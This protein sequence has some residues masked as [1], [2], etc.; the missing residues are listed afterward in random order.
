[1]KKL[2]LFL[3]FLLFCVTGVYADTLSITRKT[4]LT[5]ISSSGFNTNFDQIEAVVNGHIDADNLE[6][7]AVTA[8]KL[9]P[10]VARSGY[11]L[12]QHTDG[13]LFVDVSDTNPGLELSDG[14]IRVKA[15]DS[16]IERA[17]G[18]I[19]LKDGGI[20]AAKVGAGALSSAWPV[21]AVFI[22]TVSTNPS[23]LLGFG[24]W[25]AFGAGRML[26]GINASD[27]DF[28]TVLETG[29]AK[30]HTLTS[31]EMPSHTHTVSGSSPNSGG[32]ST[33]Q[34][35]PAGSDVSVTTGSTGGG[36]AHSIL[37]PYVI[38]YMWLRTA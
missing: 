20:T 16:T 15:D 13:S 30:T 17:S 8:V 29:G 21:G 10:D 35:A 19:Q 28:D 36:A 38:V 14:G 24:T 37:N 26:V 6:D 3:T 18:G 2:I 33:L 25:E 34:G 9:N 1:M 11:G 22:S 5:A 7:D 4:T 23:T 12:V 31:N 32:T 27:T